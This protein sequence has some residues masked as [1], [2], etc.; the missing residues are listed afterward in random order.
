M[1][2][3]RYRD[4]ESSSTGTIVGVLIGAVAG[5]AAGMLVAQR[6]GGFTGLTSKIRRRGSAGGEHRYGA[7]GVMDE[8]EEFEEYPED[9][10]E[11]EDYDETLEERVLEAFRNDPILAERAIDIGS[12]SD[13][14]IELAG[15][16][17]DDAE[18]RHAVTIARG[19]PGVDTV[20]NRIAIGDDEERFERAA[21]RVRDGDPAL[22]EARW[23]GSRVGTG[24]RRQ[25]TSDEPGR[26]ADPKVEL[27]DRWNR[28]D[29]AI[30]NAADDTEGLAERR[31]R[32][33]RAVRGDRTGGAPVAP[34]GVPKA[35]H[36][37]NPTEATEDTTA[38][39]DIERDDRF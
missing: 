9:E 38:G 28:A 33:K 16:V 15:W 5:F 29:D 32:T 31:S 24:R 13:G 36:V 39:P 25:G 35:D 3:F 21:R 2:P 37:A 20:V 4:E 12:I 23:E 34:T 17:E 7:H 1:S 26:H 6:V 22:T 14:V 19:V 18:A 8:E 10:L 30:R 11:S 27:E